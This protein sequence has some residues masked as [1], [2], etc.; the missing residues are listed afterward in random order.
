MMSEHL[1]LQSDVYM[2]AL[3]GWL[4]SRKQG[5]LHDKPYHHCYCV[6][7]KADI[8]DLPNTQQ[9]FVSGTRGRCDGGAVD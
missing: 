5:L 2:H 6:L 7:S 1:Y 9:L 4:T 8:S 3:E